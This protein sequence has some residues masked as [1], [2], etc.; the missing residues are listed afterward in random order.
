M[1]KVLLTA[2]V[3]FG[4]P[5]KLRDILW[6]LNTI[7]KYASNND[8]D[9]IVVMGDLFHDRVNLNIEVYNAAYNFFEEVKKQG[10]TWICFPGNHDLYL[11]HSWR[12]NSLHSLSKVITVIEDVKLLKLHGQRFWV[13]PF[14]HYE[15]VYMKV[16]KKIEEQ[17]QDGDVLLTHVGVHNATLNECFLI[18]NWSVVN[19]DASKFDRVFTGHFHC[20]QK[21]EGRGNVWYPGSP[22]PF[23]FDEGMVPHGFIEYDTET[24]KVDFVEIF[25][26]NLVPGP[27][28][29]DY[30]TLI[31][32]MLEDKLYVKGDNVRVRLNRDYTK[33][34]L[35]RIRTNLLEQGALNVKLQM[36]REEKIDLAVD[37]KSDV[38]LVS[39]V[40][41][42]EKWLNHDQPKKLDFDLLKKLNIEIVGT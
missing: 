16:L 4:Y 31:D 7:S 15:T 26:L 20:H 23:R 8:I 6:S 29:A 17:Y 1:A 3:H 2:D 30:V 28:P 24:R 22:I 34:E 14:V 38:S 27:R 9:I 39:P 19:F 12:I 10:Q 40:D 13:L 37:T 36:V 32:D 35:M 11:R 25:G 42:F 18:K 33:D 21:V 41:L 5:Q